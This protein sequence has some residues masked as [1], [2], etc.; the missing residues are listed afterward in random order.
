M[1]LSRGSGPYHVSAVAGARV[2]GPCYSLSGPVSGLLRNV[3]STAGPCHKAASPVHQLLVHGHPTTG[4]HHQPPVMHHS[5]TIIANAYLHIASTYTK[6][7]SCH[8]QYSL[9]IHYL[10]TKKPQQDAR[11][12]APLRKRN[13]PMVKQLQH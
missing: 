1:A 4:P 12:H 2:S 8:G 9:N 10:F 7:D 11:L 6:K 13:D 3:S 5:I